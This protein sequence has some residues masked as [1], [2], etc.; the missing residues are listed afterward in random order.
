MRT[1]SRYTAKEIPKNVKK[2]LCTLNMSSKLHVRELLV[3]V[4][5][6]G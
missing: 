2:N 3:R 1:W 4:L 5:L 6:L